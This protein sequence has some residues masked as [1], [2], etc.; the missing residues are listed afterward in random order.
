MSLL[1]TLVHKHRTKMSTIQKKYTLYNTEERKVI[2]VIIPKEKGEPLKA[3][4]GKKP[5]CVNRNVKIKDERT[6]IFTKGCELLTRLLA[7]ECEI[8]GSTENL[9]VHHIRKL[10]D[11]KERYRGRNEPPDW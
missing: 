3:S 6:D 10:K 4:F 9:N 8:C 2:G 7:N 1:K 11:L 5:I